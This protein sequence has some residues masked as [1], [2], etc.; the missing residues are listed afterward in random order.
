[1]LS[2][3]RPALALCG[4]PAGARFA[5]CLQR[6]LARV[7]GLH[8]LRP[9]SCR[10]YAQPALASAG[11][12]DEAA[13]EVSAVMG[14]IHSTESFSAVDGPGVRFLVFLQ[15]CAMRCLFCSNPDTCESRAAP[16]R[17]GSSS[18]AGGRSSRSWRHGASEQQQHA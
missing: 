7:G 12:L 4:P 9:R 2:A 14:N 16:R 8:S 11:Q 13:A 10:A 6:L 18:G 3:V 5:P 17:R 15:G 1:M